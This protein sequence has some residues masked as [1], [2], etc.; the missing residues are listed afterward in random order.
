MDYLAINNYWVHMIDL[1]GFGHSGGA[2]GDSTMGDLHGDIELVIKMMDPELPLFI[3]GHS[4]GGGLVA[5]LMI[6]NPDLNIAGVIC[7][8]AL[9][10]A[11]NDRSFPWIFRK[12]LEY[13]G[14]MLDVKIIKFIDLNQFIRML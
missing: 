11:P 7:S 2:R 6:K 12:C 13:S 8:S 5:S 3:Y 10:G 14:P 1:S 4:M 9:F